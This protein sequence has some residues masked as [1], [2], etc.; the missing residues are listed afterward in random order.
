M[1]NLQIDNTF[2]VWLQSTWDFLLQRKAQA[3]LPHA[4]LWV[5]SQGIGKY[6]L[7]L[8]FAQQLLCSEQSRCGACQACL[9][10]N[11][12]YHPDLFIISPQEHGQIKIDQIRDMV[13][14]LNKTAQQGGYRIVIIKSAHAMN[15]ASANALLKTVEEPGDKTLFILLTDRAH[16]ISST[17]RSRCQIIKLN[18][19]TD[20]AKTWLM[21]KSL[22]ESDASAFL[23]LSD[24]APFVALSLA[25]SN[26]DEERKRV[27][28]KI[29]K[30]M[31]GECS[32][33]AVS[34]EF[35]KSPLDETLLLF[36][37][38]VMDFIRVKSGFKQDTLL[39]PLSEK[40]SFARWYACYDAIVALRD[41]INS[42]IN[43]NV[44]L[45]LEAMLLHFS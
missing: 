4:L 37:S 33:V 3:C 15:V 13:E 16:F 8:A 21:S 35:L 10:I 1:L 20:V 2:P 27:L 11:A 14:A 34:K 32:V 42:H 40:F 31:S 28:S 6:E 12:G 44:N 25:T 41:Q 17:L 38:I 29:E 26:Y 36:Q 39:Q 9:W 45:A 18:V 7:S 43:L 24:N 23:V 5:G 30:I 19:D 22:S